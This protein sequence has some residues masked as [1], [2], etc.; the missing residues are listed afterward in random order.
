M[1]SCRPELLSIIAP[2][3]SRHRRFQGIPFRISSERLAGLRSSEWLKGLRWG[4]FVPQFGQ[5]QSHACRIASATDRPAFF[6]V[7]RTS[8]KSSRGIANGYVSLFMEESYIPQRSLLKLVSDKLVT[9]RA[10]LSTQS[11]PFACQRSSL[12][13]FPLEIR[14]AA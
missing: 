7:A 12:F 8:A 5:T 11:N 13:Q 9:F 1:R 4:E 3:R 2:S 10:S 6:A 14:I